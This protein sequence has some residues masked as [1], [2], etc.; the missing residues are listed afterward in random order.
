MKRLLWYLCSAL[1][2]NSNALLPYSTK[3]SILRLFGA[4]IGDGVVVKPHVH[5]KYPWKLSVGDH[6]WIGEY[7]W[8]DNLEMVKIGKHCCVS[9]GAL[10]LSG[11]HNYK[12][13]SF[14]LILKPIHVE[15]G[16]WIGAKSIVTQG[17]T[18][19]SHAV[20]AVGS[21]AS[22][23]LKAFKVYRGNPAEMVKSREIAE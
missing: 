13:S 11:N 7:V 2:F 17:I 4:S 3:C 15:D 18:V 1:F 21:V 16:A 5:I 6:S 12:S 20:L 8:I 19:G 9:Q 10:I 22:Q 14:D 23:D